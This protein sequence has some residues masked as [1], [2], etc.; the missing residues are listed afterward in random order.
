MVRVEAYRERHGNTFTFIF[1]K[2][3]LRQVLALVDL[4]QHQSTSS[5]RAVK[6][7]DGFRH[8][9]ADS[10]QSVDSSVAS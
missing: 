3:V 4:L 2:I 6:S 8:I 7:T 1:S 5:F 9:A 10:T